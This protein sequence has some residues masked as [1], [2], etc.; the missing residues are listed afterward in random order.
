MIKY[1]IETISSLRDRNGNCYHFARITSTK[2][3][4][5]LTVDVASASNAS[6]MVRRLLN[7]PW[8][9]VHC[10]E[11]WES[12]RDWQRAKQ[13]ASVDLNEYDVTATMLRRLNRKD[14]KG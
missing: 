6:G 7:L 8:N 10:V 1:I 13:F 14:Y 11:R 4:N 12:I 3:G 5:S 2:T 9:A